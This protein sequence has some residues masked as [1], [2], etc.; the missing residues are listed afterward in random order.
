MKL[1]FCMLVIIFSISCDSKTAGDTRKDILTTNIQSYT[2]SKIF[3]PETYKSISITEKEPVVD[4]SIIKECYS[5]KHAPK[6]INLERAST[7]KA[8][9]VGEIPEKFYSVTNNYESE[10]RLGQKKEGRIVIYLDSLDKI[11]TSKTV[12]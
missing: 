8:P 7:F 12:F 11:V 2:K 10:N 4:T 6:T 9:Y 3:K 5:E 1:M